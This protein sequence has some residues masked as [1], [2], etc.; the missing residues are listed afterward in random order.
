MFSRFNFID[1]WPFIRD[2]WTCFPENKF[3]CTII[4]TLYAK[5]KACGLNCFS[6]Q[7]QTENQLINENILKADLQTE[8]ASD[9][10]FVLFSPESVCVI[11]YISFLFFCSQN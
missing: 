11:L 10:K 9:E 7:K 1:F 8:R 6:K 2:F 3:E 4:F 5:Q